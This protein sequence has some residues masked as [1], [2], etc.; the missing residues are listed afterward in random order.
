VLNANNPLNSTYQLNSFQNPTPS[1]SSSSSASSSS[2]L[3]TTNTL[4]AISNQANNNNNNSSINATNTLGAG[5][6][7]HNDT[8]ASSNNKHRNNS[9]RITTCN[10]LNQNAWL[11]FAF[12]KLLNNSNKTTLLQHND[13]LNNSLDVL[14]NTFVSCCEVFFGEQATSL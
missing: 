5:T 10:T 9:V 14:Q 11:I 3:T 6:H 8:A 12:S 7:H 1:S 4:Q 2:S 13:A